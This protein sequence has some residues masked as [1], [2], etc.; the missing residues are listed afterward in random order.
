MM[1][2]RE[3]L[4]ARLR[5]LPFAA[6]RVAS[7]RPRLRSVR[8]GVLIR[9][10][11][12]PIIKKTPRRAGLFDDGGEGGIRTLGTGLPYTRFP[13]EPIRPLWHLSGTLHIVLASPPGWPGGRRLFARAKQARIVP[14]RGWADQILT[15]RVRRVPDL[16]WNTAASRNLEMQVTTGAARMV[17]ATPDYPVRCNPRRGGFLDDGGEGG[18]TAPASRACPSGSPACGRLVS[19][20]ALGSNRGSHP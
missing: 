9:D 4:T 7:H 18:M 11:R 10:P 16:M 15:E 12:S 20:L 13:G 19:S 3:G 14:N 17:P 1:A 2:E 5:R 6:L 8:T